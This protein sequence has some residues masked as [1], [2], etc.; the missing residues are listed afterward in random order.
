MTQP[1]RFQVGDRV[2][3]VRKTTNIPKGTTGTVER[4]YP[5]S[6]LYDVRFDGPYV[7]RLMFGTELELV[8][9]ADTST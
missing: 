8:A 4:T 2:R 1:Q 3:T 5:N 7:L 9:R 6:Q